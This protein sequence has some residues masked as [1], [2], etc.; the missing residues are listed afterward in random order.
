MSACITQQRLSAYA[1]CRADCLTVLRP[2][3][4]IHIAQRALTPALM[5]AVAA[6]L[7]HG[8]RL[9]RSWGSLADIGRTLS[10]TLSPETEALA[11]DIHDLARLYGEVSGEGALR[12]RLERITSDSCRKFHIDCVNLRLLCAYHGPGVQWTADH[13]ATI[14]ETPTGAIALLK[15]LHFPGFT[16]ETAVQHRSP[17]L[18]TRPETERVRL[19]LTIDAADACGDRPEASAPGIIETMSSGVMH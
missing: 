12:L 14:H 3:R 5:A 2:D 4:A 19:L 18:S 7:A 17:P 16:A 10:E 8:S 1:T 11:K 13:G 15:G 9:I 6:H